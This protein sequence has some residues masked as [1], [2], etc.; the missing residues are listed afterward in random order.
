MMSSQIK[1]VKDGSS[2]KDINNTRDI[3][4][5][6]ADNESVSCES[7][8]EV[9]EA[10]TSTGYFFYQSSVHDGDDDWSN[11]YPAWRHPCEWFFNF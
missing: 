9:S 11:G 7:T 5:V 6:H 2:N 8:E 3:L 4:H 1:H 10:S